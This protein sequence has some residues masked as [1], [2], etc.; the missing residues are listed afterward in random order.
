[1]KH[2]KS[3]RRFDDVLSEL[4]LEAD[5]ELETKDSKEFLSQISFLKSFD[6]E[7]LFNLI[8]RNNPF[9]HPFLRFIRQLASTPLESLSTE[10][11]DRIIAEIGPVSKDN[12]SR[13][14]FSRNFILSL[15]PPAREGLFEALRW[16]GLLPPH[17]LS[18]DD[19][20]GII[21]KLRSP[22]LFFDTQDVWLSHVIMGPIFTK[23]TRLYTGQE[24]F[25]KLLSL[26]SFL[27]AN[28]IKGRINLIRNN[29][30]K[31]NKNIPVPPF[32]ETG[33]TLG[34]YRAFMSLLNLLKHPFF[35]KDIHDAVS[36]SFVS[37]RYSKSDALYTQAL[38]RANA[39]WKKGDPRWHHQMAK[40][41]QQEE[42]FRSLN[43][44][45]LKQLLLPIST[46]YKK[47]YQFERMKK[48]INTLKDKAK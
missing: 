26:N 36:S 4:E 3:I 40:D 9:H 25:N 23:S 2:K 20:L 11:V 34:V 29:S 30:L 32:F 35:Q 14:K 31:K 1:M 47:D 24:F 43:V 41:L 10:K 6:E 7:E 15:D 22:F 8:K 38:K 18:K 33:I 12:E 45:K 13:I 28:Q 19:L 27:F 16:T 5:S 46:P 39:L 21:Q 44:N 17:P 37:R 48:H 42:E